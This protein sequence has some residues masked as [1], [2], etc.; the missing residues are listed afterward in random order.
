M[1]KKTIALTLALSMLLACL[2]IG[3]SAL[4]S[5]Y[6]SARTPL[7]G[8]G[9]AKINNVSL[10]VEAIN[11]T[12]VPTGRSFSFNETV[13]RRSESRGYLKA[14][15]GRGAIVT[16]GGVAQAATTLYLTLLK[17][18]GDVVI[19]PAYRGRGL[20]KALVGHI[21]ALPSLSG[22]RGFLITR[23]AHGL[24]RR[25]GYEVVNDRVMAKRNQGSEGTC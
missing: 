2:A 5:E 21:E 18:R 6:Y 4:A 23:D 7:S 24:Y 1:L 9:S 20:G 3:P 12:R 16:G 22:L 13:G 17:V 14:P 10:A 11:G 15:N 8:S 25:F 19:D